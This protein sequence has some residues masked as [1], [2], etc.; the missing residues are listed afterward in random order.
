MRSL[1]RF[2]AL[3]VMLV[4]VP[5]VGTAQV[6]QAFI[7]TW[8]MN[9]AKSS[10]SATPDRSQ[11]SRWETVPGGGL[12]IVNDTV[13]ATG[14]ATHV[15]TVTMLDGK[16]AE[17]KGTEQPSTRA[18]TR[19]DDRTIQQVTRVNGKVTTTQRNTISAD[20]KTRTIVTTGTNAAGQPVNSTTVFDRQ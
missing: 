13:E 18:Y 1:V 19:I 9:V 10:G 17:R 7:G 12:K 20:G 15:E 16:E 3:A 6:P 4:A 8:V 2:A 5:L 14:K 11:I